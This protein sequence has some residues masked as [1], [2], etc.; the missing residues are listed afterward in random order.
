MA[1]TARVAKCRGRRIRG[2]DLSA[3][4][5]VDRDRSEGGQP[6]G[7]VPKGGL[8]LLAHSPDGPTG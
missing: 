3:G 1:K 7:L 6:A 8:H 4:G 2:R 5:G